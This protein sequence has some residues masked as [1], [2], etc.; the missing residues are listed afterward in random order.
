MK[1]KNV[2]I[3][4]HEPQKGTWCGILSSASSKSIKSRLP[5]SLSFACLDC[6]CD[7]SRLSI[8]ALLFYILG[9][10]AAD[11]LRCHSSR[12]R[13]SFSLMDYTLFLLVITFIFTF[14]SSRKYI[15][16][17]TMKH[18]QRIMNMTPTKPPGVVVSHQF[19]SR[20]CFIDAL[21]LIVIYIL[22]IGW[23]LLSTP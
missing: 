14:C 1:N 11:C 12:S 9:L 10:A 19:S 13:A 17:S 15:V 18:K 21:K 6:L 2:S 7:V 22:T 20:K 4:I 16:P 3:K 23:V 8:E 5:S